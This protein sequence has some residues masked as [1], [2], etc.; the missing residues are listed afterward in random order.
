MAEEIY[1]LQ[2]VSRGQPRVCNQLLSL[3]DGA[4]SEDS[5]GEHKNVGRD[6]EA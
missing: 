2:R 5:D 1:R 6:Y 3:R 4:Q